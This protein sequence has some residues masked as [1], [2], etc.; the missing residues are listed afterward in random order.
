MEIVLV[1]IQAF[2]YCHI[3]I[4]MV[5]SDTL[6]GQGIIQEIDFLV[7]TDS[8][9]FPIEDKVRI[10]NRWYERVI[11]RIL[12]CDG[13]WQFDDTNYS[14]L[15]IAT[16]NLVSGQQ[17]YSFATRFLRITRMEMKDNTGRWIPIL[18]IDQN[19]P[20]RRSLTEWSNQ[21]GVPQF[22]D[23]LADSV[24]LYPKPN[25]NSTGGLKAYFQ[26]TA[27]LFTASDT[28]KEPGFAS[29]FHKLLA[30][31]PALE[32]AQANGLSNA[33]IKVYSDEVAQLE[34]DIKE[35]YSKR[36]KDEQ[37]GLRTAWSKNRR[38]FR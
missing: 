8:V 3:I 16:T 2:F 12:E 34:N 20:K 6:T 14:T 18:P 37:V 25:Y 27:D 26:R 21:D 32:Y 33:K 29:I 5:F 13:R 17:D 31:G 36:S 1:E 15:P 28:T 4:Y 10:I 35:F 7:N 38:M 30:V 24:F 23:K 22:Y 19:D 11:G 9:K